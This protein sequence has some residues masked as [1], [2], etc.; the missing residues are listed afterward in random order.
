MNGTN[1]GMKKYRLVDF[2]DGDEEIIG[3]Y[4]TKKELQ[5]AYDERV[6]ETDG[7]CLLKIG[8]LKSKEEQ[9]VE[10]TEKEEKKAR[11]GR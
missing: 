8:V 10:E 2:Y 3:E 6:R 4:D 1:A 5:K 9:T 7:E 11:K